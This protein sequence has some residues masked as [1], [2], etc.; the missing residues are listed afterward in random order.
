M[1]K[2]KV[3]DRYGETIRD[4]L[5]EWKDEPPRD[6]FPILSVTE[7]DL[8]LPLSSPECPFELWGV[9]VASN[10]REVYMYPLVQEKA[11]GEISSPDAMIDT[12]WCPI[13]GEGE[14]KNWFVEISLEEIEGVRE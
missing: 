6:W 14:G 1:T 7:P 9:V 8:N 13:I 5:L 11:T 10:G 12:F 4:I 2:E 3:L